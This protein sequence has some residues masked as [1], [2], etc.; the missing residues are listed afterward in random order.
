[1]HFTVVGIYR[2]VYVLSTNCLSSLPKLKSELVMTIK[3]VIFDLDGTIA[4]FNLDYKTVRAEIRAYL[5]R[6][7]IPASLISVKENI[8]DMVA[9]A[10]LFM[11][12]AGK[13]SLI[14]DEINRE[15]L[16][17]AEKY[18]LEAATSTSLLPGVVETLQAV[19]QMGMKTALCTIN[20]ANSTQHILEKFKLTEYFDVVLP[21]NSLAHFKP[22]PEHCDCALKILGVVPR[23]TLVV[24]DSMTDIHAAQELKAISV[25]LSTGVSTKDQLVAEGANYI[26]TSITDLPVLIKKINKDKNH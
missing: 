23:E 22:S 14:M 18:E 9:K 21:R 15:A 8:F 17:I 19:K 5:I 11:T 13:S 12:N 20:S 2:K 7:G 26:M 6:M 1:M 16:K 24:G 4:V 25:G 3:A 10:Q